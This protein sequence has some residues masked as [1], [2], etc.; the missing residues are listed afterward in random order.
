MQKFKDFWNKSIISKVI[1]IFVGLFLIGS[2][3]SAISESTESNS[4]SKSNE[5]EIK[6]DESKKGENQIEICDGINVVSNC[7]FDGVEY[8][9]YKYYPAQ[10]EQYHYETKTTYEKKV[11]GHCTLCN[12]GTR[13]PSCSTGSGTCSHHGGVAEWNAPIY[14]NVEHNEQVKIV[15]SPFV[16]ERYEKIIKD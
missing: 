4:V 15:D 8:E 9:T 2:V 16:E 1:V 6:A 7:V 12:D 11:V 3:G 10:E 5:I 14:S 13:S